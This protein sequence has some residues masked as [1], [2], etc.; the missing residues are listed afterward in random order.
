MT[1]V[2][3]ATNTEIGHG[4]C[5]VPGL[6]ELVVHACA[7]GSSDLEDETRRVKFWPVRDDTSDT[8]IS[9][10]KS[11][12]VG[13]DWCLR[14]SRQFCFGPRSHGREKLR[15]QTK[16]VCDT[17]LHCNIGHQNTALQH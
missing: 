7:S 2:C 12:C 15:A 6:D 16:L 13:E 14:E 1:R 9:Q 5:G 4:L 10:S 11:S 3:G 17:D 8:K